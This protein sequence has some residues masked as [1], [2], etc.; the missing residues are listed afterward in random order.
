MIYAGIILSCI[1]PCFNLCLNIIYEKILIIDD[2]K[3]LNS[4][5]L[6]YLKKFN[7]A[8][9]YSGSKP[10]IIDSHK[11]DKLFTVIFKDSGPGIEEK[12]IPQIFE[13]FYR[14]DKSRSRETGGYGL[15]LCNRIMKAHKGSMRI[16]SKTG[17]GTA[18]IVEF[19][20]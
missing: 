5:L 10:V 1:N 9:R 2:D 16:E 14:I 3:K 13:P 20:L 4:L 17:Q 18:V 7:F 6:N 8:V 19:P 15:S 11:T 12:H